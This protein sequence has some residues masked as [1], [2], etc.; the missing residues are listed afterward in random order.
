VPDRSNQW[1]S[2][3]SGAVDRCR[4]SLGAQLSLFAG[5]SGLDLLWNGGSRLLEAPRA[6][7]FPIVGELAGGRYRLGTTSFNW[8]GT[9]SLTPAP[10]RWSIDRDERRFQIASRRCDFEG[11]PLSIRTAGGSSS[12][13]A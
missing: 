1:V 9:A 12:Y 7:L 13:V 3:T 10:L 2:F 8:P 5:R 6:A 11:I 4:R